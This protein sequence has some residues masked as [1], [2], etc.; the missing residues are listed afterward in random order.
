MKKAL[1]YWWVV[2]GLAILLAI[3][4]VPVYSLVPK[5]DGW[6][7]HWYWLQPGERSFGHLRWVYTRAFLRI[8]DDAPG[9]DHDELDLGLVGF[10][11]S[12][13]VMWHRNRR[14]QQIS[15]AEY[16]RRVG[17]LERQ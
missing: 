6:Q 1:R 3:S 12:R 7:T 14:S 5:G 17:A 8:L 9:E 4:L 11:S 13:T 2:S 10:Q 15:S 16:R